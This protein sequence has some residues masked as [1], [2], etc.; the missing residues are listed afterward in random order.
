MVLVFAQF[1]HAQTVDDVIEKYITAMG[2]KEKLAT[3]SSYRMEGLLNSQGYDVTIIITK[4]THVGARMDISVANTEKL[5]D[6]HTATAHFYAVFGQTH[7]GYAG[8]CT[9]R[10]AGFLD[11]HGILQTINKK[12]LW[13]N[14]QSKETID[15]TECYKLKAL[16][17]TVIPVIFY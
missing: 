13:W 2:G 12:E 14:L 3:L 17:K 5:Q 8:R 10:R 16:L 1:A 9:E 15:G 11:L 7:T 4:T 6:N